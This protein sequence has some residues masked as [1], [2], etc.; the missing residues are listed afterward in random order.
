[1]P[2]KA[3]DAPMR[4]PMREWAMCHG[5]PRGMKMAFPAPGRNVPANVLSAPLAG[6]FWRGKVRPRKNYLAHAE[7][8]LVLLLLF[9]PSLHSAEKNPGDLLSTL[10]RRV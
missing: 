9:V 6:I 10:H 5:T 4:I 7:T 8:F 1:L 2:E 3:A